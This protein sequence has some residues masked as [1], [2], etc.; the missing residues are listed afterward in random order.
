MAFALSDAEWAIPE[1]LIPLAKP[2]GRPRNWPMRTI[3]DGIFYVI[4]SGC[5]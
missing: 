4:R 2:G 3:L 1:P 5:Q